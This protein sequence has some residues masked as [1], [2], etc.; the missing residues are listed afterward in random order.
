MTDDGAWEA[1]ASRAS[2][3]P[4]PPGLPPQLG[5]GLAD[6]KAIFLD[7]DED[8]YFS[9]A[10]PPPGDKSQSLASLL[11]EERLLVPGGRPVEPISYRPATRQLEHSPERC[12]L[13]Q[14]LEVALTLALL[15][16]ELSRGRL[17]AALDHLPRAVCRKDGET[18]STALA[19]RFLAARRMVPVR[20]NCLTDTLALVRFLRSRGFSPTII[21][22]VKL[23]PFSAHCWAEEDGLLLNEAR[24]VAAQ[25]IPVFAA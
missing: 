3:Q 17:R 2:S 19:Q 18:S 10:L 7:L 1:K 25:F 24:D 11:D 14:F 15:R 6:G 9:V 12:T 22:G 5:F 16:R 4:G 23:H 8:R 20:P 13:R 21:F